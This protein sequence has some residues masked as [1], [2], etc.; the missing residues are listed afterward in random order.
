MLASISAVARIYCTL[1]VVQ[2]LPLLPDHIKEVMVILWRILTLA[3][4][5]M[6]LEKQ[7]FETESIT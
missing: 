1:A 6:L 3:V 5:K 2:A 4:A 7:L